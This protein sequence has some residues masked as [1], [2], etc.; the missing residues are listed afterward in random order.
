MFGSVMDRMRGQLFETMEEIQTAVRH[1][2][3][4]AGVE[5][6][7]MGIFEFAEQWEK[8]VQNSGN[9][10]HSFSIIKHNSMS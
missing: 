6:C 1:S 9:F 3:Q 8:C 7:H 2:L 4:N 5:F 10:W